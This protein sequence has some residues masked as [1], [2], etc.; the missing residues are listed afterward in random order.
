[1]FCKITR[2]SEILRGKRLSSSE[3]IDGF[4]NLEILKN[5]A[6]QTSLVAHLVFEHIITLGVP[7]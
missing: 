5:E 2:L 7:S 6:S 3:Q 4:L 1:M